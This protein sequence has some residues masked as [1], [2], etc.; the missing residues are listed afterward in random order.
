M[1]RVSRGY[2]WVEFPLFP[3]MLTAPETSPSRITSSPSLLPQIHVSPSQPQNTQPTPDVK[4]PVSM[5][6][7]SPLLSVHLLKSNEGSMQQNELT[8]LVT[9]LTDRVAVLENDLQQTKKTYNTAFTKIILRV[10][11]LE[12]QVNTTKAR[13]RARIAILEEED[14]TED[15]SKQERKIFDIDEDPNIS[16]VQDEGMT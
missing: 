2:S 10:K 16:L 13:R 5:P 8:N 4:E 11:S 1:K 12:K 6:H 14:A 3:I 9:K 7:D 15:S